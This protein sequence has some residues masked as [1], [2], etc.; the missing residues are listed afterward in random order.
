MPKGKKGKVR[1][2]CKKQKNK[3]GRNAAKL[4][5]RKA[6][7]TGGTPAPRRYM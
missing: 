1:R 4:D 7:V 6:Q 3:S 2:R 5:L